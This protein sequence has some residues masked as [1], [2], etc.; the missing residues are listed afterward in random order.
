MDK[1]KPPQTKGAGRRAAHGLHYETGKPVRVEMENGLI[2]NLR[3]L[4]I[5]D[6]GCLSAGKRADLILIERDENR[7]RLRQVY[8]RGV[9]V[10]PKTSAESGLI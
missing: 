10:L 4:A 2:R 1:R 9:P 7:L 8:L 6:R 5:T 3:V